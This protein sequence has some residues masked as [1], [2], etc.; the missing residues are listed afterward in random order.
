MNAAFDDDVAGAETP[1]EPDGSCQ[2]GNMLDE[3]FPQPNVAAGRL[4]CRIH[5]NSD[6]GAE[7]RIMEWT[8]NDLLVI[9]YISNLSEAHSWDELMT[10]WRAEAGPFP[11]D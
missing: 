7:Y 8:N 1:P 5:T 11:P 6:T 10:F 2:E 9:G 4:N 3:Y